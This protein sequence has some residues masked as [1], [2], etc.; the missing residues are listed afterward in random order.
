MLRAL[1]PLQACILAALLAMFS[2]WCGVQSF[3]PPPAVEVTSAN[4]TDI[5][6]YQDIA[7]KVHDGTPYHKAARDLQAMH[8]YPTQPFVTIRLPT[9]ALMA[10]AL[11]WKILQVLLLGVLLL[12]VI[13]WY[14]IAAVRSQGEAVGV[15]VMV[16]AGG[17]MVTQPG[18]IAMHDF[19]AGV[20][21]CTAM[22]FRGTKRWGFAIAFA[23]A[24]VLIRELALPFAFLA[25]AFAL[26]ERRRNEA[27]GWAVLIGLFAVVMLL[28]AQAVHAVV[29]PTD[30][31]SAPWT[32]LLGFTGVLRDL[33]DTSL[34]GMLP[35][36]LAYALIPLALLGWS[37]APRGYALFGLLYCLGMAAMIAL[38]SRPDNFYW[39][40]LLQP[41]WFIGFAFLP[42]ALRDLSQAALARQPAAL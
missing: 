6:L 32:G 29:L 34:L 37:A 28:H 27:I 30:K 26:F 35:P 4:Y 25:L 8:N 36:P 41:H 22:T 17:A 10:A 40:C 1:K 15:A 24:A 38:F 19:W 3:A 33:T 11:G 21:A 12:A 13:R 31:Q 2:L 18:L 9:L 16:L 5:Q 42:R 23:G 20:L 7:A 14:R 39:A